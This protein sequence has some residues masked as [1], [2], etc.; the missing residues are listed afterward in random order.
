MKFNQ[1]RGNAKAGD[2]RER[3]ILLLVIALVSVLAW[4]TTVGSLLLYPFTILATWFHEMGHG[5]AAMLTGSGFDHL[6]LFA[7]G[8]G[9]ARILRPADGYKVVD[10]VIS[11]GGPFGPAIA[12]AI[13]IVSSRNIKTTRVALMVLGLALL[14]STVIW[15]RS[16]V[17]WMAIPG[18]GAFILAVGAKAPP[19]LQRFVVQL[20]GVQ[21]CIS[22][23]RQFDYL[24]SSGG[25]VGGQQQLS[26]TGA[27]A[28]VLLLPF[29][30][31][32]AVISIAILALLWWSF[33]FAFRP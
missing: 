10:A 27:I 30:F 3:T 16:L 26:D 33:R 5:L 28:E 17:G 11:A 12:G 31:W 22:A 13:L 21:A 20:L 7:D 8:S 14:V 6:V 19:S 24:F 9:Y 29:W 15:V 18:L 23:W 2:P 32:G 4:Q 1:Q 25:R